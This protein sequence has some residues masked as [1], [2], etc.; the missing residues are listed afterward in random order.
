MSAHFAIRRAAASRVNPTGGVVWWGKAT[1][2]IGRVLLL[3]N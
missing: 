1:R 3:K 2:H